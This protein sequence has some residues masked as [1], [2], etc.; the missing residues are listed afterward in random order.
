M[1]RY[2]ELGT[3][4]LAAVLGYIS[5]KVPSFIIPHLYG[6]MADPADVSLFRFGVVIP[7]LGSVGVIAGLLDHRHWLSNGAATMMLVLFIDVI[8]AIFHGGHQMLGLEMIVYAL[9]SIPGVVGAF[10]GKFVAKRQ[11]VF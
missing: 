3:F 6:E 4:V 1:N 10:L 2:K 11:S 8:E 7:L 5:W 9:L